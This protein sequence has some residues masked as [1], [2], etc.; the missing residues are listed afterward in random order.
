[1]FS[2]V[3]TSQRAR[4][5]PISR[6]SKRGVDHRGNPDP[7]LRHAKPG[8]VRGDPEVAGGGHFK[9]TAEAPARHP[10]DD[11][12]RKRPHRLAQIAQA[13]NEFLGRSLVEPRHF[14]DIGPADHALF[15]LAG[16][17]QGA[18]LTLRG[19]HL[20]PVAHTVDDGRSQDV[21]RSGIADRQPDDAAG[22]AIDAAMGVEHVHGRSRMRWAA[23]TSRAKPLPCQGL[24]ASRLLRCR[25]GRNEIDAAFSGSKCY[26]MTANILW[27]R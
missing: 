21:E 4:P 8:I 25:G 14:L 16:D 23:A 15:A 13:G 20:E 26:Y 24:P 22:I 1:M 7:D 3:M 19:Q 6:G 5:Q 12:R 10:R 27:N 18:N 17:D 11:R 9:A 2:A